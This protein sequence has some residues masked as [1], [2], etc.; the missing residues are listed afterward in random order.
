MPPGMDG[1]ET[2]QRALEKHPNQKAVISS[3][4]SETDRMETAKTLGASNYIR[5][6]YK[7]EKLGM[8]IKEALGAHKSAS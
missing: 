3:G 4:F 6:P 5:K 2:Y 1:L 8:T 7:I